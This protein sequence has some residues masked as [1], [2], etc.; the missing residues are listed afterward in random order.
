MTSNIYIYPK[1]GGFQNPDFSTEIDD[2][3]MQLM[4]GIDIKDL[5]VGNNNG[6]LPGD[7]YIG[8]NE[9]Y[10]ILVSGDKQTPDQ[11]AKFDDLFKKMFHGYNLDL[12]LID[13]NNP[14][15]KGDGKI[16]L[17]ELSLFIELNTGYSMSQGT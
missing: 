8:S 4:N 1:T 2:T 14:E 15:H 5:D 13:L 9:L 11:K 10:N 6:N 17:G 3:L 7:G 16:T 12:N